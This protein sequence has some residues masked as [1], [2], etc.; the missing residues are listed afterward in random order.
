VNT[1]ASPSKRRRSFLSTKSFVRGIILGISISILISI[2]SFLGLLSGWE[3][4]AFD[5]MMWWQKEK[6]SSE[7][8]LIEIDSQDYRDL[9][10]AVSPLSR[11][12]LARLIDRLSMA[13]PRAICL[14]I[15]L[16]DQTDEDPYLVETLGRLKER[17]IPVV[18]ASS[19]QK[20]VADGRI[21]S[22]FS[23]DFP[24]ACPDNVLFGAT[25]FPISEDE[26]IREMRLLRKTDDGRLYPSISLSMAAASA[27][28]SWPALQKEL[29]KAA[30]STGLRPDIPGNLRDLIRTGLRLQRQKIY[31]IGD[32]TSFNV[33]RI[34]DIDRMPVESFRAGSVLSQKILLIGGTF[35][36]SK[37]FYRTPKGIMSG[38]EIIA[39]SA[40]TVLASKPIRP[41]NYLMSL[42]FEF[43][44]V[45]VLSFMFLRFPLGKATL[46]SALSVVPLTII[47]S[48]VAFASM[49][50]W[51]DFLPVALAVV[52]HGEASLIEHYRDMKKEIRD[53]RSQLQRKEPGPSEGMT[54]ERPGEPDKD[55]KGTGA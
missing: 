20:V 43:V 28:M 10:H 23:R 48:Q 51:L 34:S 13:E 47:G 37:D 54:A 18:L 42:L 52:L 21:A 1:K 33:L 41:I 38:A 15:S 22:V 36:E 40:E 17:N 29:D 14:D 27:K 30:G 50:R 26:T 32:K 39:N 53:L 12:T 25:D 35:T 5:F 3:N 55:R 44:I 7:I 11:R 46:I 45:L 4:Q 8:F 9:F 31:F 24:Y 49:S 2:L 19:I 16:R 6:R